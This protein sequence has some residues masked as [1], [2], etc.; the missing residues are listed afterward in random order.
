MVE[1]APSVVFGVD[2]ES[3]SDW[4]AVDVAHLFYELARCEGVEV[5]VTGLPELFA[6]AFE[7][8]GGFAFDDL[9]EGGED[10]SFWLAGEEVNVLGH[11]DV[12]VDGEVVGVPGLFDDSFEDVF[13]V[14]C[15]R[16]GR[17]WWQLKVMKWS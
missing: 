17:R 2:D 9:E 5:V 10:A 7:G 15:S 8:Y 13:G 11:E 6:C 3:A 4:V 16:K 14:G 1:A 12:G